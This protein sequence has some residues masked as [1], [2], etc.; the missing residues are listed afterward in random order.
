MSRK[1]DIVSYLAVLCLALAVLTGC[2]KGLD[3]PVDDPS[4]D[5]AVSDTPISFASE[6]AW[7]RA[8]SADLAAIQSTG[9]QVWGLLTSDAHPSGVHQFGQSGTHVTYDAS[10]P[11]WTY[12]PI[13]YWMRGTYDF[14]AIYPHNLSASYEVPAGKTTHALTVNGFDV[15]PQDEFLI[16]ITQDIDGTSY[17]DAV[18]LNFMHPLSNIQVQ[19]TLDQDDFFLPLEG[20]GYE[21]VGNAY[22]SA[23]GFD[24]LLVKGNMS[25]YSPTDIQW[26]TVGDPVDLLKE[27]TENMPEITSEPKNFL[28]ENGVYVIPQNLRTATAA[29]SMSVDIYIAGIFVNKTFSLPLNTGVTEW[30]PNTKYVYR[31]VLTQDLQIE[32][33]VIKV[34]DWESETLGGFIVS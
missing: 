24:D 4:Q 12:S 29:L 9:F 5:P 20:G 15:T 23:V 3:T 6:D 7:T 19:L 22:V 30:L 8:G 25:A 33:R 21:Q 14:A 31:G 13:R 11:A 32:F 17:R 1:F 28:G 18:T 10:T 26:T 34:N 16:A 27:Y 2:N